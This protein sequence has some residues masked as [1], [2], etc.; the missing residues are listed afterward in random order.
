MQE[1]GV[2][3]EASPPFELQSSDN[4]DGKGAAFTTRQLWQKAYPD[5]PFFFSE[6]QKSDEASPSSSGL[7][8]S[9][10]DLLSSTERQATFLWQVSGE[11]FEDIDFL[12]E[13]VENYHK[14]LTLKPKAKQ[15]ILV[16]TYQVDLMWH[17]HILSSTSLYNKDCTAMIG[18]T[19]HHD[20]SLN[21]Q[22]EGGV[23]DTSYCMTKELW[24]KEYGEA[25]A[26]EGGMY[27]GEPPS[28]YFDR[29][30]TATEMIILPVSLE[31]G[32]SSTSPAN[33]PTQW[34][35]VDDY[36]SDGQ[37]AFI[38]TNTVMRHQLETMPHREMYVLGKHNE[39]IGYFHLETWEAHSI[40][41]Q[42][43]AGRIRQLESDIASE[44][45]C[46]G[47]LDGIASM[48]KRLVETQEVES[49]MIARRNALTP[50]GNIDGDQSYYDHGGGWIYPIVIWDCCGGACGG[51][52]AHSTGKN[53][54]N[55]KLRRFLMAT[56]F[57]LSY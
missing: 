9:G 25:Y 6:I 10:F 41:C 20:D 28:P 50:A 27:R 26:V 37:R 52:V 45:C 32:A 13:G 7:L 16:P 53:E 12:N 40:T 34:A 43:L 56:N 3:L 55:Y 24:R 1:F 39:K 38:P 21:D 17:T 54:T 29:N 48:E 44:K 42:R 57:L 5:E 51:S 18:S 47:S 33:G 11:R 36:A 8:L 15:M 19:F 23:L 14:F 30:W 2:I 4:S 46:C 31:M 49:I 22:S 35:S